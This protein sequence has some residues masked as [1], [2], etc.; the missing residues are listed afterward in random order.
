MRSRTWSRGLV[1][2]KPFSGDFDDPIILQSP[3]DVAG[4]AVYITLGER[5]GADART[6]IIL[7][8]T[9]IRRNAK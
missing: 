2:G 7:C 1:G 8:S 4:F 5:I 6:I 3:D 9:T